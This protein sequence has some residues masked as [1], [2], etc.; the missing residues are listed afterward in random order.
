M[1]NRF[2]IP[3]MT[4][5]LVELFA[6]ACK[7]KNET[8]TDTTGTSTTSTSATDTSA[9][10]STTDTSGTSGTSATAGTTTGAT[11]GTASPLNDAD[12][13]TV[14]KIAQANMAE[15]QAGQMAAQKATS[16]EVK[17]FA[18]QM[19]SDHGKAG[20]ELK[21]LATNKGVSLPTET[22]AEHKAAADKL[23]KT[24][25][26]LAFDK[27]YMEQMVKDH[28]KAAAAFEKTSK[29]A[30]DPDLKN[31]ATKTL[32]TIQNHLKMAKELAPK[33]K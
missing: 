20:D 2:L 15:I 8:T 27:A 9:T 12:K 16:A 30:K 5:A 19:V 28:E 6:F 33:L 23:T 29:D 25:A 22:D 1:K 13:T 26:G 7:N 32:P 24:A 3:L 18:N 21:Q 31:W 11:G 14:T 17:S 10:T 4:V